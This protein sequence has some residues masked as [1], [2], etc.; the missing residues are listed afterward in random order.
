MWVLILW[1]ALFNQIKEEK[2]WLVFH[3]FFNSFNGFVL[4]NPTKADLTILG[5]F[6]TPCWIVLKPCT[7]SVLDLCIDPKRLM[8]AA[9]LSQILWAT[10]PAHD[11]IV[12]W[13][14]LPRLK[15]SEYLFRVRGIRTFLFISL[16]CVY[17]IK[18]KDYHVVGSFSNVLLVWVWMC[19]C[20]CV[21]EDGANRGGGVGVR[22][23]Y[24]S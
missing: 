7:L 8:G 12:L 13:I 16:I 6:R 4:N 24:A 15:R 18:L 1:R 20:L 14:P 2:S 3:I 10:K 19:V 5:P 17:S 22:H 21:R 9:R 11:M 23:R